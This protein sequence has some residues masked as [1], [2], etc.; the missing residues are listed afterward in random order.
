[1]S[2]YFYQSPGSRQVKTTSSSVAN[3]Q[4]YQS[5]KGIE[6]QVSDRSPFRVTFRE[7]RAILSAA[8]IAFRSVPSVVDEFDALTL[9]LE[10]LGK[11]EDRPAAVHTLAAACRRSDL[12]IAGVSDPIQIDV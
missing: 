3:F 10:H 12:H 4:D 11:V 1:M 2:S 7:F 5:L 9:I 8:G 6:R